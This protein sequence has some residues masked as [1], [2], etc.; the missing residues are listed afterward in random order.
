MDSR[1]VFSF[2]TN[3]AIG[4]ATYVPNTKVTLRLAHELEV[5]IEELFSLVDE[6]PKPRASLSSEVLSATAA[7][8]GQPVRICRM[9]SRWVSVPVSASP[10]YLPEADGIISRT[11]RTP[12][13]AKLVVFA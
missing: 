13:K 12:G 4:A 2:H 7:V 3:D 8:S 9:G 6:T 10:H 5:S 11:G 1:A